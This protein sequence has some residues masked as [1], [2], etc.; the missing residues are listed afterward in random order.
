MIHTTGLMMF[1][2][3][4]DT[5]FATTRVGN[6]HYASIGII[7]ITL[8]QK[9]SVGLAKETLHLASDVTNEIK[10]IITNKHELSL[11]FR[12]WISITGLPAACMAWER[13]FPRRFQYD[14]GFL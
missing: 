4:S 2:E 14:K 8:R 9:L 7:A 5:F 6:S 12:L 1:A 13:V 10:Y 3:F 11:S